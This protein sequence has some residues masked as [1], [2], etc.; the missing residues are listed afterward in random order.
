[1]IVR[2]IHSGVSEEVLRA[3]TGFDLGDLSSVPLTPE[4]SDEELQL[5]R[6]FVDPGCHLLPDVEQD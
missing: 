6:E 2:S 5:L 3:S 4:P 1:M